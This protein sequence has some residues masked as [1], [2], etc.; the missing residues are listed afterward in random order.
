MKHVGQETHR[1]QE[2]QTRQVIPC[3]RPAA[4]SAITFRQCMCYP[5]PLEERTMQR[6]TKD[7]HFW[8]RAARKYATDPIKDMQGYER[9]LDRVSHWVNSSSTVLEVGCGT[10]TTALRLAPFVSGV[11]ATDVSSEM[12]AIAREKATIQACQNVEFSVATIDHAPGPDGAYDAVLAFNVLHLTAE[13]QSAFAR[14]HRLLKTGGVF[15]SKTPCLSEMNPLIRIAVPVMR[16]VGKAPYVSF[17]SATELEAEI[18]DAG[19]SII[20]RGRHGSG[21]KDA[22][23][24]IVARKSDLPHR[25]NAVS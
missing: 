23:I 1:S 11:I 7:A 2:V 8:D 3:A 25:P 18:V 10:G 9:T 12:V 22:R 20:E 24:F 17:F 21:R 4:G 13:R 19:F 15:I 16:L 6:M 14:V 5:D